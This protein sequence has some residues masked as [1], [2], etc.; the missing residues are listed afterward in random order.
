MNNKLECLLL[1]KSISASDWHP[2]PTILDL[3][4]HLPSNIRLGLNVG[5]GKTLYLITLEFKLDEE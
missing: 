2:E 1:S 3:H 5:Q 4:A